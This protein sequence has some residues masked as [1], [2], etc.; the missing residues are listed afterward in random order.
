MRKVELHM[1]IISQTLEGSLSHMDRETPWYIRHASRAQGH[2]RLS[3]RRCNAT[4]ASPRNYQR[5]TNKPH[6]YAYFVF[7][8]ETKNEQH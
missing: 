7:S 2:R 3:P 5:E 8:R 4:M 6:T 1:G